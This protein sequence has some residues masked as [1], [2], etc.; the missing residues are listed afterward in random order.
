MHRN[1]IVWFKNDLRLHDQ[2]SLHTALQQSEMVY[3][4]YCFDPRQFDQTFI[5]LP[6][7]G[8]FRG[9]FLLETLKDLRKNLREIGSDLIIRQGLPE[10]VIPLLAKELKATA[11]Y[12]S[13]EATPEEIYVE[14][15]VE[16][17]LH[18]EGVSLQLHW[19]STLLHIDDIPW[20]IKRL[21]DTFTHFRKEAEKT[22]QIRKT[23]ARPID[24]GAFSGVK[25][26]EIPTLDE[27]GLALPPFDERSVL[28]FKG[29]ESEGLN[30][31]NDY[32]WKKDLL[33]A[34]KE[35]RNG[36][37]GNEYSSKFSAWL[38]IGALS[39]RMIYEEIQ[40]YERERQKNDS[41]Y[42]LFFEL[43][44][45]DFFRFTAK[46]YGH[47]IFESGGIREKEMEY[48]DDALAFERWKQGETG[49]PFI[50]A[51]MRELNASGFM[52]NRGRQ[53]VASFLVK[54]LKVNWTWGASYF[55]SLLID[56]DACSNWGNWNYIAGVGNDPR[57]DRYF[58]IISQAQRYDPQGEYIRQ[59]IPELSELKGKEAHFPARLKKQSL[60]YANI[61][62]GTDYPKP[63]VSF[64]RWMY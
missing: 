52:S 3:P 10:K 44:W 6:K 7:T 20:P 18:Q 31:L 47:L 14:Q 21:P 13:K 46:K 56:Y 12:A 62:L 11:V 42:W 36:L 33:K 43:L 32:V 45:R 50:D 60:D 55:E 63:I 19:Q 29:G 48:D 61:R 40:K 8:S 16:T 41:T 49:I 51:N 26:G 9:R 25:V 38:S 37:I 27:L 39:P 30:R 35:T 4:V 22:T 58:N 24:M 2:V 5:G 64:D 59:W 57:E 1:T 53:N 23:V 15:A 54:D 28:R 17:A 34:Y